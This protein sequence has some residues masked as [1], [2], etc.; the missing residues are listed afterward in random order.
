MPKV[1]QQ[2]GGIETNIVWLWHL[3][4]T[5]RK[6]KAR[7]PVFPEE[8]R[9]DHHTQEAKKS[10]AGEAGQVQCSQRRNQRKIC[11]VSSQG[12]SLGGF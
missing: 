9:Q 4:F 12:L 3:S 2:V 6:G 11:E 10:S 8:R 5:S 1:T 7:G